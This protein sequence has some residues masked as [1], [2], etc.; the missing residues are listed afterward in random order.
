MYGYTNDDIYSAA[1]RTGLSVVLY[2]ITAVAVCGAVF[3]FA[4]MPNLQ[5]GE[6]AMVVIKPLGIRFIVLSVVLM[7]FYSYY[8]R[9]LERWPTAGEVSKQELRD[10][11]IPAK[12]KCTNVLRNSMLAIQAVVVLY[13]LATL[14]FFFAP[15]IPP[16]FG[17]V[18]SLSLISGIFAFGCGIVA[19]HYNTTLR[20]LYLF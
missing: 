9:T 15:G 14:L 17:L 16:F 10:Q 11:I 20:D 18:R 1:G 3:M 8:Q 12:R 19:M 2:M 7:V 4:V 13:L 5:P 6:D